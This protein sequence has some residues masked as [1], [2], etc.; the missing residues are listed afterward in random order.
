MTIKNLVTV[1]NGETTTMQITHLEQ[2][3][4]NQ[5][6]VLWSLS[7][8]KPPLMNLLNE[9][10]WSMTDYINVIG[11]VRHGLMIITGMAI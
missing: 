1:K 9:V 8:V 7:A 6:K 4:M 2:V 10:K 5:V 3:E 11:E